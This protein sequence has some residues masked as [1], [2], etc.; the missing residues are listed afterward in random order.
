MRGPTDEGVPAPEGVR[1]GDA[2]FAGAASAPV[3]VEGRRAAAAYYF[4]TVIRSAL[5]GVRG[6]SAEEWA[7][8]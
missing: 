5:G 1:S 3:A 4:T 8:R 2:V 6:L 7:V